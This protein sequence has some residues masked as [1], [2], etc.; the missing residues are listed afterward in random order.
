MASFIIMKMPSPIQPSN[1]ELFEEE[2]LISYDPHSTDLLTTYYCF[3]RAC[4]HLPNKCL[5]DTNVKMYRM[6]RKLLW[7][8]AKVNICGS[9][10][11]WNIKIFL[12]F[13][14]KVYLC[15]NVVPLANNELYSYGLR[16][17]FTTWKSLGNNIMTYIF[18]KICI[19]RKF[20]DAD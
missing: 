8:L 3:S 7:T 20:P 2:H 6:F 5:W 10:L 11:L 9:R 18:G 17:L 1:N 19:C 4:W 14:V 13:F 12:S 16:F 15:T